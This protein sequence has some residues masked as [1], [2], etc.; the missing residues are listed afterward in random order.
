[1]VRPGKQDHLVKPITCATGT[2]V[3]L[4]QK[5]ITTEEGQ[6][7]QHQTQLE[8]IIYSK[9]QNFRKPS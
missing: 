3:D 9:F 1:M 4:E 6:Q 7:T 2:I 5:K 8:D